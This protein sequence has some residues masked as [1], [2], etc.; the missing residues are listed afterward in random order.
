MNRWQRVELTPNAMDQ[1]WNLTFLNE[2]F[3]FT[4][5]KVQGKSKLWLYNLHYFDW[6]NSHN[7]QENQEN[8]DFLIADWIKENEFGKG[9]GWEPYP[10][11][12]RI[13]NWVKYFL[14]IGHAR[15]E[16]QDSLWSQA[17]SLEQDVEWHLLG[18][19]LFAN[20]KAL[21]FAG[22]YFEGDTA[23]RWSQLGYSILS[24]ELDEQILA[25]GG[26]FE[27]SP[28]YHNIILADMLDLYN[29]SICASSGDI[30]QLRDKL[31]SKIQSMFSWSQAMMHPDGDVSFFNDSARNIAPQIGGLIDYGAKLGLERDIGETSR[32]VTNLVESGYVVLEKGPFYLV[33]DVGHVGPDYIP[34]HAH[35]DTLSFELSMGVQRVFVNSGTSV[36]GLGEERLRQRQT[37]SHNTVVVDNADSSEVWGGFR[38]AKRAIPGVVNIEQNN[39]SVSVACSHNGYST[40]ANKRVHERTWELSEG[41]LKV[42]DEID[43]KFLTATAYFYLHPNIVVE[44]LSDTQIE[45]VLPSNERLSLVSSDVMK[46]EDTTWHPE[47][48]VSI[49]NK[50][51]AIDLK[52]KVLEVSLLK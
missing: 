42:V 8:N 5:W 34:G 13:V 36:Y 41:G 30:C 47:F 24:K 49:P 25:D 43:G 51:I 6:L 9:V 19:H 22:T 35:A 21:I 38:V 44:Q 2:S 50:R 18:N 33:A 23:A 16:W 52:N 26:N 17:L 37:I 31:A 7:A 45:L 20:A 28:M 48:G 32:P 15:K 12:L 10:T 40:F 1:N 29:L 3:Q 11:S 46:I 39:D 14:S 27:L 4:D